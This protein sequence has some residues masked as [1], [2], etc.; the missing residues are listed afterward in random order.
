MS[1]CSPGG[2]VPCRTAPR[3][4]L[5][6]VVLLPGRF[7]ALSYCSPGGNVPGTG[8]SQ[9]GDNIHFLQRV[10][11]DQRGARISRGQQG[12]AGVSRG[13]QRSAGVSGERG[14]AEVSRGQQGAAGGSRGQLWLRHPLRWQ[15]ALPPS[16]RYPLWQQR[17]LPWQS[18]RSAHP[19]SADQLKTTYQEVQLYQC[20]S[21]SI[22]LFPTLL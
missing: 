1:Y 11:R 10:V 22:S 16:P 6:L 12:P 21:S 4:V 14:S 13:Q 3:A 5:C 2:T 7:C 18:L 15:L 19:H 8:S 17:R 9:T 20:F